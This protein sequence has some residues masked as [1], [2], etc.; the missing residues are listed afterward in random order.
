MFLLN[1]MK[2]N[3]CA[4]VFLMTFLLIGG[5]FLVKAQTAGLVP[6]SGSIVTESSNSTAEAPQY[7]P[8]PGVNIV[9]ADEGLNGSTTAGSVTDAEGKFSLSRAEGQNRIVV[10]FVGFKTDTIDVTGYNKVM[11]VLEADAEMLEAFEVARA[12]RSTFISTVDPIKTENITQDE[13]CKAACCSLAE[14]FETNASIDAA[15][16][17]GVSGAKEIRMLGLDGVYVQMMTEGIPS[18]RGLAT[19][20]GLTHIPGPWVG[21]IA[22]NKGSGSV[23]NGY[24]AMT[25]QINLTWPDAD[26]APPLVIN[27][28]VND[29]GRS[30]ANVNIAHQLKKR[31]MST[32]LL[33]HG[34]GLI[35][36]E[37]LN[38]KHDANKDGFWDMPQTK[39]FAATNYWKYRREKMVGRFGAD[40]IYENRDAGQVSFN[41][42]EIRDNE[43]G[44]GIGIDTRRLHLFN[45]TGRILNDAKS[46]SIGLV[47]AGTYHEQNAFFGLRDYEGVQRTLYANLLFQT[48]LKTNQ[49]QI[50]AGASMLLDDY[51]E[52]FEG[53]DYGRTDKVPGV[54]GEY[55]YKSA[56]NSFNAVIGN[57]LDVHQKFGL[58]VSPRL[59]L[60][61]ALTDDLI[62]RASA[63]RAWRQAN[64]FA[65]N[66]GIFASARTLE[67]QEELLPEEA[68]NTGFSLTQNFTLGNGDGYTSFDYYYT[69]FVNQVIA[70]GYT[71]SS[72]LSFYNLDGDSYS[73][74]AQLEFGYSPVKGLDLKGAYKWDNAWSTFGGEFFRLPFESIHKGLFNI[75]Y[76]IPSEKWRFDVTAQLNGRKALLNTAGTDLGIGNSYSPFY[77]LFFVQTSYHFPMLDIY[78]GGENVGNFKQANPI[79]SANNPF[80]STFDA[81]NIWGPIAG[82]RLFLKLVFTLEKLDSKS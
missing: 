77:T 64:I 16:A 32:I 5:E 41:P 13:L 61:Y 63:G 3:S 78:L 68:W 79:V 46:R 75:A 76:E 72:V 21:G 56:D 47:L 54:F 27:T 74:S 58:K 26:K 49:H 8:I 24:E 34:S 55:T 7:E 67:V 66:T 37:G 28:F 44:Y 4:L 23:Q 70:D 80:G 18:P 50:K 69:H 42:N 25:G 51:A 39:T 52:N 19:T 33:L 36:N 48:D 10:S 14:S 20:Y 57:R 40:V 62:W 60:K 17:D 12:K 53:E 30:E 43:N 31:P 9:W 22:I 1:K 81:T 2:R 6:L 15:D 11:V 35:H 45:K 29:M 82:R 38:S 71:N 59:H 73:H 65:E